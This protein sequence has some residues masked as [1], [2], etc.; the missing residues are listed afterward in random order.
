MEIE[1]NSKGQSQNNLN[2]SPV[3]VWIDNTIPTFIY[4]NFIFI[5]IGVLKYFILI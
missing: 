3:L 5:L 2:G 1:E 4:F